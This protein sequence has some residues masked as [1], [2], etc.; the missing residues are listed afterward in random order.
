M[1]D[2]IWPELWL[3]LRSWN[4]K[5]YGQYSPKSSCLW[6]V[7]W[8]LQD[9]NVSSEGWAWSYYHAICMWLVNLFCMHL[10]REIWCTMATFLCQFCSARWQRYISSVVLQVY[11][12]FE[13]LV[14]L[15]WY[16]DLQLNRYCLLFHSPQLTMREFS[17]VALEVYDRCNLVD[18]ASSH[19]LVSKFMPCMPKYNLFTAK[20]WMAHYN[21]YHLLVSQYSLGHQW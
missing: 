2:S 8:R 20:L 21:S 14:R 16:V 5:A 9:D 15:D 18:P 13:P 7:A 6:I 10:H 12:D 4:L 19:M 3:G 17:R 11:R 1:V